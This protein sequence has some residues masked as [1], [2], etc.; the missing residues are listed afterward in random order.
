MGDFNLKKLPNYINNYVYD[1]ET[2][3]YIY[4]PKIGDINIKTPLILSPDEFRDLYRSLIIKN[5]FT[6]Q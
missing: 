2:D 3:S 1:T 6:N 5:Y 4:Q